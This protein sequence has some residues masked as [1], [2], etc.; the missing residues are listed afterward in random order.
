MKRAHVTGAIALLAAA[1]LA[2]SGCAGTPSGGSDAGPAGD[3]EIVSGPGV[4]LDTKTIKVGALVP[5]SGVFAGAITNIE[6]MDAAFH[7]AT[8]PG[9]A[10]EGWTL[11]VVNQDTKYDA[12]TAIP[13]YEGFKDD[14]AMVSL[15]LGS[16]IIDAMLP[17]IET[18]K[19]TLI[20]GGTTP[21]LQFADHLVPSLPMTS[22]H[23]ASLI[24]YAVETYDVEDATFCSMTVED[25]LGKYIQENFDFTLEELGLTKGIDTTFAPNADQLTAQITSM[26][27]ADCDVVMTGGTG[28]FLQTL[29]VQS[30]QQDFA[31][32]VLA[33]NS[34]YNITLATGPGADWLAEN[35][36]ISVPGDEWLGENAPGQAMLIEDLEA[37]NPDY[38]PSANAH[39]TGYVNGLL[40]ADI[41]AQALKNGDLS[42]DGIATA[43]T[44]IGTWEDELGLTGGDVVIGATAAENVPPHK[45][46]MFRIDG[47]VPTGL[48]LEA[49]NYDSDVAVKYLESVAP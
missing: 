40:T 1:G 47:S 28:G 7:R 15:V 36:I 4:D 33:G 14:V 19:M 32:L 16:T 49:Y 12:A 44:E 10:M 21:N 23:A 13:L 20:P 9:G 38:T 41:L 24:P 48:K 8:Q 17:S 26:K 25:T 18:D 35:A 34:A 27:N 46:S 3:G 42:R 6:G 11:E 43:A 30:V 39:L 45:L 29:A 22:S 31:P 5:V 2:L 37:I